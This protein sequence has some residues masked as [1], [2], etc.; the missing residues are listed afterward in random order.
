MPCLRGIEVSL[1][2]KPDDEQIPEYPHPEG[3][4]ARILDFP[5]HGQVTPV[6]SERQSSCT[7][8]PAIYRK[9]GPIVSVYIPSIPGMPFA[10]NYAINNA[11]AA[12]CKYVF[13]RLYMNART[14]ASWGIDPSIRSKGKVV[15][16]LWAPCARYSDEIG[17]EGRNFVFLPGQEYKSVAEDG[18]L[19]E[20]QAF[21][22]KERRPRAP[23]L[24]EFRF[25]DNYGIA[26]PS[27]G[28][29]DQPQDACF[30]D[31]HLL[32]AKDSPFVSFRLH[33]RSWKNLTQ[34][35]LIPA[36][37]L[38]F[39]QSASP[40]V[41]KSLSRVKAG[42]GGL[43]D[44]SYGESRYSQS[45]DEAVFL[46]CEEEPDPEGGVQPGATHYFLKSP[47]ELFPAAS[48]NPTVPQP[49]KAL[50]DGQCEPQ[51]QRPL[52]ELPR[53]ERSGLSRRSSAASAVSATLSI[54]PSLLQYLDER[55]FSPEEIE[56]GVAQLVQLP[57]SQSGS[58]IILDEETRSMMQADCSISDYE[59]S[60]RSTNDSLSDKMLSPDR[61]LPMTG[62]GLEQGLAF[63]TPPRQQPFSKAVDS[64]QSLQSGL[65]FEHDLSPIGAI[66]LSESEWMSRSPSPARTRA[67][68]AAARRAVNSRS[69]RSGGASLLSGL[70]K[71]KLS[72]SPRKI[73][74]MVIGRGL[75]KPATTNN[76]VHGKV[77]NWI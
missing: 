68:N 3:T 52:P 26:A 60:P 16:S 15:N 70:R 1:T 64:T 11:P 21:R 63:F 75:P 39:L 34:L 5:H 50:R 7:N 49:S 29:L 19:I 45:P 35:N 9:T 25:H 58:S 76:L 41:L 24:E 53:E 61:Y 66:T 48:V 55:S 44:E 13:F 8:G 27:I 47:P 73:A 69:D 38:E 77:G 74:A 51:L 28:L 10:I 14:I 18:G 2:T 37:E 12:P 43:H 33:Y 56:V 17:F 62:S 20:I 36:T 30:Y 32:D 59:T 57:Q 31:W 46:D 22:A 72:A 65:S 42:N 67:A 54:A 6:G 4:S 23:R 71:K 40:R